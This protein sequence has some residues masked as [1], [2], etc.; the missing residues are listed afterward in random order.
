MSASAAAVGD[1]VAFWFA[2]IPVAY[3]IA[4]EATSATIVT[5]GRMT[6]LALSAISVA[7]GTLGG[8]FVLPV[9]LIGSFREIIYARGA[10]TFTVRMVGSFRDTITTTGAYVFV[11]RLFGGFRDP[12][13]VDGEFEPEIERKGEVEE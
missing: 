7:T 1:L 3:S 9:Q 6:T 5:L 4:F 11:V 13:I 2:Y 12:I 8:L 10:Y